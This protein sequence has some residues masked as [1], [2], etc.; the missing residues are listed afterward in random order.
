MQEAKAAVEM[1][2]AV[3]DCIRDLRQV[4]SGELYSRLMGFM[5]MDGY[6]T[7]IDM[8]KRAGVITVSNHLIT[9]V[10]PTQH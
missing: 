9:W 2:L 6:N 5:S 4:P 8:L 7:V 3:S 1:V 10:G